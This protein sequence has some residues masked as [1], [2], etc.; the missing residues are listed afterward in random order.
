MLLAV[1]K[2]QEQKKHQHKH[3]EH[4]SSIHFSRADIAFLFC[5]QTAE[6]YRYDYDDGNTNEKNHTL[7]ATDLLEALLKHPSCLLKTRTCAD[8]E[9]WGLDPWLL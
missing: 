1:N 5:H 4:Q 7:Y 6:Q 3:H 2:I 9:Y 8:I